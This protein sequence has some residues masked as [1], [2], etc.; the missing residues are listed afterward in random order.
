LPKINGLFSMFDLGGFRL[1]GDYCVVLFVPSGRLVHA[2]EP[3]GT[4]TVRPIGS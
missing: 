4:T 2:G 1:T 3:T